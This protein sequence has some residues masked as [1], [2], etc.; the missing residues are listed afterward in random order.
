MPATDKPPRHLLLAGLPTAVSA[1]LA[2]LLRS[3]G[4]RIT[5]FR[6]LFEATNAL[7]WQR[8]DAA[9]IGWSRQLDAGSLCFLRRFSGSLPTLV[10][11]G[12]HRQLDA[13]QSL[14]AGAV[15]FVRL[16]LGNP[17][18]IFPELLARLDCRLERLP[19]RVL[20]AGGFRLNRAQGV[21]QVGERI[22]QLNRRQSQI[23]AALLIGAGSVCA[24]ADLLHAAGITDAK[25]QILEAYVKQ[26]RAKHPLLRDAIQT[27]YG[28]GYLLSPTIA[29]C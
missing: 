16:P 20:C 22:L 4:H 2:E 12:S 28:R 11:S 7:A 8:P 5:R 13:V 27:A 19:S 26:L 6:T 9:L 25:P 3:E 1:P 21:L 24:R 29:G 14:R 15:D 18:S 17:P 10:A 23:V